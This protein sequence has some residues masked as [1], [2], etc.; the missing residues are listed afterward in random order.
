MFS[1]W[2]MAIRD[3]TNNYEL[4][5]KFVERKGLKDILIVVNKITS[6]LIPE[7][8]EVECKQIPKRHIN[9]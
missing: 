1:V 6:S 2:K 8:N 4:N 9:K 5:T 3:K 7:F